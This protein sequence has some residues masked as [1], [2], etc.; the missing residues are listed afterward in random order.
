MTRQKRRKVKKRPKEKHGDI[1]DWVA[2][3]HTAQE[4]NIRPHRCGRHAVDHGGGH[5]TSVCT[6]T[7]RNELSG[8]DFITTACWQFLHKQYLTAALLGIGG[9]AMAIFRQEF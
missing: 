1:S 3:R 4:Q 6:P 9:I 5:A 8:V 7:R 2:L